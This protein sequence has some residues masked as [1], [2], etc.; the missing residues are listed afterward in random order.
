MLYVGIESPKEKAVAKKDFPASGLE[1]AKQSKRSDLR[2]QDS[3]CLFSGTL[4]ITDT[5]LPPVYKGIAL[6]VGDQ[7]EGGV[8]FDPDLMRMA[9]GW[10]GSFIELTTREDEKVENRHKLGASHSFVTDAVPGWA[11]ESWTDTRPRKLGP[12]PDAWAHYEGV[13]G[14]HLSS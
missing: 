9:A 6:Q 2:Y 8:V 14:V 4:T 1:R 3:G 5:S 12:L 13:L 7:G 11:H 10:I